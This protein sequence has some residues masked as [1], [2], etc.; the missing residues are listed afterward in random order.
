MSASAIKYLEQFYDA[1]DQTPGGWRMSSHA[2]VRTTGGGKGLFSFKQDGYVTCDD[3][4][5]CTAHV[6]EAT[7]CE[8]PDYHGYGPKGAYYVDRN[9]YKV[10][11]YGIPLIDEH[12]RRPCP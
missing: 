11:S 10:P 12:W 2:G 4:V 3:D 1:Y 8:G 5:R 7:Y 9:G 6:G